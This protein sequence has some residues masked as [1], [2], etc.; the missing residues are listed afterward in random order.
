MEPMII[1]FVVTF[2]GLGAVGFSIAHKDKDQGLSFP[3]ALVW[4][5]VLCILLGHFTA[6][7]YI[8]RDESNEAP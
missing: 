1:V 3:A 2:W 8:A 6:S 4:P 5:F 7:Y